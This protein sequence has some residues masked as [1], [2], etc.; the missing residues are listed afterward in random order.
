MEHSD[1]WYVVA[2]TRELGKKPLGKRRFGENFVF[3]RDA[4]GQPVCLKARCPHRGADL[5]LG[6]L[7]DGMIACPFHGFRFDQTGACRHIPAEP[8]REI[9][10]RMR[11]DAVP[12]TESGGWIW[13]WRGKQVD[14]LPAA[15]STTLTDGYMPGELRSQWNAH[16]TR[17]LEAQ[18]DYTHLPFVHGKS[19]GRGMDP[20][21]TI[22][23]EAQD[24]SFEARLVD[25]PQAKHQFI[26][27]LYP[28]LW[29][30]KVGFG[31]MIVSAFAP[32]DEQR[33]EMYVHW[34]QKW[35]T[36]EIPGRWLSN[37][38][39][40]LSRIVLEED[41]PVVQSQQPQPVDGS[42]ELLLS[43]DAT[44]A[45]YRRMRRRALGNRLAQATASVPPPRS[46]GEQKTGSDRGV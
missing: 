45:T 46:S 7:V 44:I 41:L 26:H 19:F 39:A 42:R 36:W 21:M 2:S 14:D 1:H 43:T 6:R 29:I 37:L 32:I 11:V 18:I 15:P 40:A 12:V 30:N 31:M 5:S 33:T 9:P 27:F 20:K 10:P 28:N 24:W 38:G 34:C 13:M 23:V 35:I 3:F 16:Y 25:T 4:E 8:D 22:E 17:V